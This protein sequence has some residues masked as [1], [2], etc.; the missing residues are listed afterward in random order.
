MYKKLKSIGLGFENCEYFVLPEEYIGNYEV[1]NI[2][3]YLFTNHEYQQCDGFAI[4]IQQTANQINPEGKDCW[5]SETDLFAR[6][7]LRDLCSI[8]VTYEDGDE[9]EILLPWD[10][11]NSDTNDF[12]HVAETKHNHHLLVVVGDDDFV[13]KWSFLAVRNDEWEAM[14][15]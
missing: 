2:H 14:S 8:T 6:I 13:S 5:W 15:D 12:Q 11:D 10:D 1:R 4:T 7:G 9:R 3:N